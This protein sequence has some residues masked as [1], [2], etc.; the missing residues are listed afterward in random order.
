MPQK[1][2]RRTSRE[3]S[4]VCGG[5][6]HRIELGA[7]PAAGLSY[8]MEAIEPGKDLAVELRLLA[9]GSQLQRDLV[10]VSTA[11]LAMEGTMYAGSV[12]LTMCHNMKDKKGNSTRQWYTV[13]S[14]GT[15]QD[16]PACPVMNLKGMMNEKMLESLERGKRAIVEA[17]TG[18]EAVQFEEYVKGDRGIK[19]FVSF[20]QGLWDE[21]RSWLI[22]WGYT[23][24]EV[25][26][27]LGPRPTVDMVYNSM[28]DTYGITEA[29]ERYYWCMPEININDGKQWRYQIADKQNGEVQHTALAAI[30]NRLAVDLDVDSDNANGLER[31]DR[32][33]EIED[34]ERV[35]GKVLCH[36]DLDVDGDG[37]PDYA[38]GYNRWDDQA[39][40]DNIGK[41]S[42]GFCK[43]KVSLSEGLDP[44]QAKVRFVCPGSDPAA[45]TRTQN[46]DGTWSYNLPNAPDAGGSVR[47]W[48]K[49]PKQEREGEYL[50]PYDSAGT[51]QQKSKATCTASDLGLTAGGDP[52]T[53]YAEGIDPGQA[54]IAVKIDPD[55]D[56]D[57]PFTEV[58]VARITVLDMDLDV[59]S[60][61]DQ[62][63]K[64]SRSPAEDL[65]EDVD[66]HKSGMFVQTNVF[67]VDRDGVPDYA[68]GYDLD[69]ES[70]NWDD[71]C[72]DTDPASARQFEPAWLQ[73][74]QL[75]NLD[76]AHVKFEYSASDPNALSPPSSSQPPYEWR[77]TGSGHL[78]IWTEGMSNVTRNPNSI[79]A[80]NPG[81][82]IPPNTRITDFQKLGLSNSKGKTKLYLEAI[83]P[84]A[85]AGADRVVVKIDPDG[86]GPA[87]WLESDAVR[88]TCVEVDID[89][90][91]DNSGSITLSD[92]HLEMRNPG[93]IVPHSLAGDAEGE[94][95]L[96][97][98]NLNVKPELPQG[99]WKL[100]LDKF[101]IWETRDQSSAPLAESQPLALSRLRGECETV[102]LDY[103]PSPEPSSES[104]SE[105]VTLE[106]VKEEGG[107]TL[108]LGS[109]SVRALTVPP[110]SWSPQRMRSGANLDKTAYVWTADAK[111]P[112]AEAEDEFVRGLQKQGFKVRG[113]S[114]SAVSPQSPLDEAPRKVLYKIRHGG[115]LLMNCHGGDRRF[116]PVYAPLTEEGKDTLRKWIHE[117]LPGW[118]EPFMSLRKWKGKDCWAVR[119][120]SAWVAQWYESVLNGN[121]ALTFWACCHSA[122]ERTKDGE[123]VKASLKERAGGRFRVGFKGV[124]WQSD[125]VGAIGGLLRDM[126]N[127]DGDDYMRS[128]ANRHPHDETV[129]GTTKMVSDGNGWTTL[130]PAPIYEKSV[131]PNG[132]NTAEGWGWGCIIF[133]TYMN[134]TVS[135]ADA[136]KQMAGPATYN[137]H[138]VAG[139]HG[140][141][142]L[143]FY[144]QKK[145][146]DPDTIMKAVGSQCR[147]AGEDGGRGL[148][149]DRT[150]PNDNSRPDSESDPKK[151]SF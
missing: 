147:N 138:W 148:D 26:E 100:S 113:Y 67:D 79:M 20:V 75:D 71:E 89:V 76:Q 88:L 1:T 50:R 14:S 19:E 116:Y 135:A 126:N 132:T 139:K 120:E 151:W 82:Y 77:R 27:I 32:E 30:L 17:G 93:V 140:S 56:G 6:T 31:S 122:D 16:R 15:K 66:R 141:Y 95:A 64:V 9:C 53:F 68:D 42:N 142:I 84:S 133:D 110:P 21:V 131:W 87:G 134:T 44:D 129:V 130:C 85:S 49:G 36:N 104:V 35:P 37:I 106:Y 150:A 3:K 72:V 143:G 99:K 4:E 48:K 124:A 5:P 123:V 118:Q 90:D 128:L 40:Y 43:V 94:D 58:D 121:R 10:L 98:V 92:D 63:F 57:A 60:D 117:T 80:D 137:H 7:V 107:N 2:R 13:V 97:Q 70:G 146:G 61:N 28:R 125:I 12:H 55:G 105:K 115:A 101:R 59:D 18:E 45:V 81:H 111:P 91:S 11:G 136:L 62:K 39:N 74:K 25:V 65:I 52:V 144:F 38:D 8:N 41:E 83:N 112:G 69:G 73:I 78:R 86:S 33:E 114:T 119:V 34:K 145:E 149:G 51:E 109:D 127:S 46:E 29:N 24:D 102:Y 22:W 108:T 96:R 54:R 103:N 23:S 47:L